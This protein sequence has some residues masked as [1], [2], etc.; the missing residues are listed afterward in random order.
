MIA[1]SGMKKDNRQDADRRKAAIEQ[2]SSG[3]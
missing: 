2:E 3:Q 1:K